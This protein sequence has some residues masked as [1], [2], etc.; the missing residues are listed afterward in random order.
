[1]RLKNNKYYDQKQIKKDTLIVIG[2]G[3]DRWQGLNTS[4]FNFR[5]YYLAHRDEI[6]RKLRIKKRTIQYEDGRIIDISDVELIY[7]DPFRPKELEDDFW[8]TFES[9]LD[10]IDADKINLFFGK[11]R[12][13]LRE[14]KKSI[15]NANRILRE[16]FSQ[17][18]ATIEIGKKNVEHI[19]GDNCLFINFN[20]TDT[21]LKRFGVSAEDEFHI[22]GEANDPKSIV[23]GH[24]T[25]PQL[26]E[27][28]LYQM[29][30]RFRG[31]Y[32]VEQIL[33]ETDKH[34]QDNIRLLCMF[35]A[36][37]GAFPV[38]IKQVFVLGHS[39]SLPDIEYFAFLADATCK[40]D[41]SD[42]VE[43]EDKM[44]DDIDPLEDL[45]LRMQYAIQHGGHGVYND[46]IDSA[47]QE[48]IAR[49]FEREIEERSRVL[50]NDF[51]K[52]IKKACKQNG[53]RNE[54]ISV[55][56]PR[57][58]DALW[59]I[60]CHSDRD[61]CWVEAVMNEFGCTRYK[62]YSTIDECLESLKKN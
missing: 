19:F 12:Q 25:H 42:V 39:M 41:S 56:M 8:G 60:S 47:Q 55:S 44:C 6:L 23:V 2:N 10:K 4:Y 43:Q 58:E 28:M 37:K 30:G 5:D 46:Q 9:S 50:E 7:G 22:H 36:A 17:W 40:H 32:F 48:A 35:L 45:H 13:G 62:T 59:H 53:Q 18:I 26:P 49:Q 3:F 61:K 29:G 34:I 33:Y 57:A 21:L 51:Q 1:M 14:M 16:A 15:R 27:E 52:L 31:L 54:S 24:S 11:D 38:D 20:Y